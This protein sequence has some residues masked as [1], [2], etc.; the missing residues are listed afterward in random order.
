M[1]ISR[2]TLHREPNRRIGETRPGAPIVEWPKLPAS[3]LGESPVFA[4]GQENLQDGRDIGGP[5][6]LETGAPLREDILLNRAKAPVRFSKSDS[7]PQSLPRDASAGRIR[8]IKMI[9]Q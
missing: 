3:T 4:T 7:R 5:L 1:A 6:C 8:D 9:P 2:N